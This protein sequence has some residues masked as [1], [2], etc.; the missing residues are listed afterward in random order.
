MVACLHAFGFC[1][2]NE[3]PHATPH[4]A[5]PLTLTEAAG[6]SFCEGSDRWKYIEE[7][8]LTSSACNTTPIPTCIVACLPAHTRS[9]YCSSDGCFAEFTYNMLDYDE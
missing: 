3:I 2:L 4:V 5:Y 9:T 6:I 8:L 7:R 1:P